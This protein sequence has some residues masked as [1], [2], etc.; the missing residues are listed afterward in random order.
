[1]V[2][3]PEDE[4]TDA[5]GIDGEL[6][7][8]G[9]GGGRGDELATRIKVDDI[10]R[11]RERERKR[12]IYVKRVA[13]ASLDTMRVRSAWIGG[14]KEAEDATKG[15]KSVDVTGERR[16]RRERERADG[17]MAYEPFNT[18]EADSV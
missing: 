6:G 16:G 8:S 14:H 9:E 11:K 17:G 18:G 10:A 4:E 2:E 15:N 12:A 13:E 3:M 5:D 7:E 1:M